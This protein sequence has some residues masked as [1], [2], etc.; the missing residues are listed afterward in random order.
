MEMRRYLYLAFSR[1]AEKM[2]P[3]QFLRRQQYFL[4]VPLS[5][6]CHHPPQRV[7]QWFSRLE[8]SWFHRAPQIIRQ[9][10]L[11]SKDLQWNYQYFPHNPVVW[12][13]NLYCCFISF[14]SNKNYSWI[15]SYAF[16]KKYSL[17]PEE[18]HRQQTILLLF[19]SKTQCRRLSS[20][21]TLL[22]WGVWW[23]HC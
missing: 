21:V 8:Y 15:S 1:L 17:S 23:L 2:N 12:S 4:L 16:P 22:A 18:Y 11:S 14:L 3:L 19:F 7:K 13:L 10:L 6:I 5:E 9:K 20:S